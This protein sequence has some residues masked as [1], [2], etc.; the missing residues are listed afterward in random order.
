[1]FR[2]EYIGGSVHRVEKAHHT[3]QEIVPGKYRR[4]QILTAGVQQEHHRGHGHGN[5]QEL[6]V[7]AEGIHIIQKRIQVDAHDENVPAHIKN[8]KKLAK[9][10]SIVQN[11]VHHMVALGGVKQLNQKITQ[12]IRRPEQQPPQVT[13]LWLVDSVQTEITK[14][15]HRLGKPHFS[16]SLTSGESGFPASPASAAGALSAAGRCGRAGRSG[17]SAPF[18][19][20]AGG[21]GFSAPRSG[22]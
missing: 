3:A 1:M 13:V 19:H 9:R 18:P 17:I 8:Q 20:G 22:R 16:A 10:N 7:A 6:T 12:Q 2:G 11:A 21:C 14:I 15:R 4:A 5:A